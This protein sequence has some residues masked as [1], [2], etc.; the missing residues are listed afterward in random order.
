MGESGGG[1]GGRH[2]V[3]ENKRMT[4]KIKEDRDVLDE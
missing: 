3:R 2:K 1:V 4:E